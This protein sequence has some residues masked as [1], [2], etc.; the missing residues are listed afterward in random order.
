[1]RASFLAVEDERARRGRES[2]K[3]SERSSFGDEE[4]EKR[5]ARRTFLVVLG[6]SSLVVERSSSKNVI[7]AESHSGD[8]MSVIRQY[9]NE[10]SLKSGGRTKR[11]RKEV[12]FDLREIERDE[13]DLPQQR[14]KLEHSYHYWQCR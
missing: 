8:P 4:R 10:L 12:S 9:T 7:G 3:R 11:E 6:L 5:R 1:M 14:P 13:E 2:A